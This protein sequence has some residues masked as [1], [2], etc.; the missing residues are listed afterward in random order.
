VDLHF[1]GVTSEDAAEA[2][3]RVNREHDHGVS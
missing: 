2:L 1:H 3:V